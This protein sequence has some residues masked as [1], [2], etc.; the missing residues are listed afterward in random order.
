MAAARSGADAETGEYLRLRAKIT[1]TVSHP[2]LEHRRCD[3]FPS[4]PAP[5]SHCRGTGAGGPSPAGWAGRYPGRCRRSRTRRDQSHGTTGHAARSA[6]HRR[7]PS[8]R[9][10]TTTGPLPRDPSGPTALPAFSALATLV[11][12]KYSRQRADLTFRPDFQTSS[13]SVRGAF[14]IIA[15]AS[16]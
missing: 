6:D 12:P 1:H 13:P 5:L 9:G 15:T 8:P 10:P 4:E 14:Q 11:G 7:F 2:G 3:F 16:H